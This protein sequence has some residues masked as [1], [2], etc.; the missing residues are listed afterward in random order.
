MIS[1]DLI[2]SALELFFEIGY[3]NALMD[4]KNRNDE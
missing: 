3:F 4:F 2:F 1:N